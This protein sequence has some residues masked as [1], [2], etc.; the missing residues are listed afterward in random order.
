L[1]LINTT[2]SVQGLRDC[3]TKT[4][5]LTRF[6]DFNKRIKAMLMIDADLLIKNSLDQGLKILC[7][8]NPKINEYCTFNK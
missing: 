4:P 3:I 7:P 1:A 8:G 5:H 6:K 2:L